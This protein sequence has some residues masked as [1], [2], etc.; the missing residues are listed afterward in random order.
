[1]SGGHAANLQIHPHASGW[2]ALQVG[3]GYDSDLTEESGQHGAEEQEENVH[4]FTQCV[5]LPSPTF[6]NTETVASRALSMCMAGGLP[7]LREE[8]SP[9]TSAVPWPLAHISSSCLLYG[10]HTLLSGVIVVC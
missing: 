4:A 3:P 9:G 8:N 1:M 10:D 2:G 5:S 7:V 6:V